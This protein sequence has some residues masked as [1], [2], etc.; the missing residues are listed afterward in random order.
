MLHW[1]TCLGLALASCSRTEQNAPPRGSALEAGAGTETI[2]LAE[3]TALEE[4]PL[5]P[6]PERTASVPIRTWI[7][8]AD[9]PD[10]IALFDSVFW[11]ERD[12]LS[13]RELIA[14]T[15]LVEDKVVLEIGTGSGLI[16]LYCLEYGARRVVATDVNP[17]AVANARFN[18]RRL[19]FEDRFEVRLVPLD[20]PGAYRVIGAAERF[21]LILSNPPWENAEPRRIFEYAYFDPDFALLRS[22]LDGL[23]SHLNP[24]GRSLLAYG[25]VDGIQHLIHYSS[26]NGLRVRVLDDRRL[27]DLPPVFVP[28]MLL[29][30]SL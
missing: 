21:D 29:E 26:E 18:A 13:L 4:P 15:P 16:A 7:R 14:T 9:L 24:G 17:L 30:V 11:D 6:P 27:E 1:V 5:P 19:G 22:L 12:T 23:R 3:K 25:A 2:A 20:D 28:G 8:V 10:R